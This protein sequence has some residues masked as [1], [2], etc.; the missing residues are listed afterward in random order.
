M[1]Q[2][3][4][5]VNMAE[6]AKGENAHVAVSM[7][8][9][10]AIE[11]TNSR[12]ELVEIL[13]ATIKYADRLKKPTDQLAI[14]QWGQQVISEKLQGDPLEELIQQSIEKIKPKGE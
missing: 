2:A 7:Y 10:T 9:R 1:K 5:Y 6:Q 14:Y 12:E 11:L 4:Q 13:G 3:Q 8:Y